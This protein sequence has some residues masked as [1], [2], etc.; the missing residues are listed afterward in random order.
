MPNCR[1]PPQIS[2]V[3][4]C[5]L[6]EPRWT[7]CS[8]N[9]EKHCSG[10]RV[11]DTYCQEAW[12]AQFLPLWEG[13]L[14]SFW[15]SSSLP[16]NCLFLNLANLVSMSFITERILLMHRGK[17]EGGQCDS[18]ASWPHPKD[19]PVASPTEFCQHRVSPLCLWMLWV[20]LNENPPERKIFSVTYIL[21]SRIFSDSFQ[22][23]HLLGWT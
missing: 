5:S 13:W 21:V 2:W 15:D 1:P 16:L 12:A 17:R 19:Q 18:V 4:T 14:H 9:S 10:E 7:V 3:R 11:P 22:R 6:I 8:F 23:D 20:F